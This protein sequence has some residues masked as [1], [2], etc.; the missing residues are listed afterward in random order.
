MQDLSPS[1]FT[2][3]EELIV[4]SWDRCQKVNFCN[5]ELTEFWIA[6]GIEYSHLAYNAP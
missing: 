1:A 4:L 2:K 6:L 3:D 5:T